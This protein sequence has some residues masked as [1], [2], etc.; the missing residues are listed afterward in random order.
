MKENKE[1]I[2]TVV[3]A[4]LITANIAFFAGIWYNNHQDQSVRAE[5]DTQVQS[6]KAEL[7]STK[8]Q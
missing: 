5:V 8:P 6:L 1:T 4:I 3:I 7:S 2:K